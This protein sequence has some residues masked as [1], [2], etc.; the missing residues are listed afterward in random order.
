LLTRLY[1]PPARSLAEHTQRNAAAADESRLGNVD[2]DLQGQTTLRIISVSG[3]EA[4]RASVQL[5]NETTT[6][7]LTAGGVADPGVCGARLRS[8]WLDGHDNIAVVSHPLAVKARVGGKR[9]R[10]GEQN[11]EKRPA[12]DLAMS[13][14]FSHE[15]IT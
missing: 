5:H 2:L 4:V 9:S 3:Q 15:R 7:I 14:N 8:A 6:D 11:G 12:D 13:S 1:A 10:T